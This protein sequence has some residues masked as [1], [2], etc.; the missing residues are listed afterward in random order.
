MAANKTGAS[1]NTTN[2]K[3]KKL[4]SYRR[5]TALQGGLV[6]SKSGRLKLGD[7]VHGQ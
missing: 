6:M 3:E 2:E 4:L 7:N 1:K 5:Q